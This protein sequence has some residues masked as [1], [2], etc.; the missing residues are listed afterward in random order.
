MDHT[1]VIKMQHA[2]F[3]SGEFRPEDS[4]LNIVMDYIPMTVYRI[5][6]SFKKLN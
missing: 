3:T 1:N 5:N 2:F 6:E 4:V